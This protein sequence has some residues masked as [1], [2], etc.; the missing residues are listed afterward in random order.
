[1]G[2][3]ARKEADKEGYSLAGIPGFYMN[4]NQNWDIALYR[5]NQGILCPAYSISGKIEGFQIRLDAPHDDK[6]ICG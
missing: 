2:L 4:Q 1:M 5:N 3:R 6:S